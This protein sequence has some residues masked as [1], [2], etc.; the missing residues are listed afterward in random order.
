MSI[1]GSGNVTLELDGKN[2]LQ[3]GMNYAGLSKNNGDNGNDGTLT[4]Q[5]KN[6]TSGSLESHGGAGGAGIGSDI[7]KDTSHIVI[8]SGEITAVGGIGAAGIGGG[9]AAF[10]RDNGR[11]RATDITIAGGTV[12]AEGGAAGEYKD[13]AV[14]YYTSS[15]GAG[16]GIGSG[17][18]YTQI[19]SKYGDD[20]YYDIT[21]KGGDVT[22]TTGVGG[23]AGIGGGSGSG[24]G[25]IEIKDNAVISAAEG[26]G[27]GAGI[28]S[29][30]L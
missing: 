13:A 7:S 9:N 10:P 29:G 15:T 14:N 21:I 2:K 28:G 12:K 4:I 23:A 24:K 18:N 17:G 16:A 30:Y 11:G 6:G 25:K 1:S 20:C 26:S 5:D 3:S 8:D 22:A 19:D 27:Y